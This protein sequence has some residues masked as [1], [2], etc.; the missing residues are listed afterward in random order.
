VST[1]LRLA[2][3]QGGLSSANLKVGRVLLV[4]GDERD[5]VAD[6]LEVLDLAVGDLHAPLVL[7]GHD[8]LHH[9]QR[10]DVEVVDERLVGLNVLDRDAGNLVDDGREA[11]ERLTT[12]AAKTSPAPK[13]MRSAVPPWGASPSSSI[14]CIANGTEAAEVLPV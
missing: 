4:G 12:W 5:R 11:F 7:G 14:R 10:V 13:P 2:P 1:P 6:G 9:R 8:D 3:I